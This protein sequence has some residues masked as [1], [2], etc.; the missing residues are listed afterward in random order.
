MA[1]CLKNGGNLSGVPT[2]S[3]NFVATSVELVADNAV[4]VWFNLPPDTGINKA[5]LTIAYLASK[6]LAYNPTLVSSPSSAP[7]AVDL[8]F[9]N[10]FTVGV[11]H[12]FIDSTKLTCGSLQLANN[13]VLAF[14]IANQSEDRPGL[15][16]DT[17]LTRKFF[18]PVFKGKKNWEALIAGLEASREYLD[19][20][21]QSIFKQSYLATATGKYLGARTSN[22]GVV[23]PEEIGL[24]DDTFRELA[25]SIINSKL[26]SVANLELLEIMYGSEST[27]ATMIGSK[28]E[29]FPLFE[30]ATLTINDDQ[31][32]ISVVFKSHFFLDITRGTAAE[33]CLNINSVLQ[34]F[35]SKAFAAPVYDRHTDRTYIRLYSGALG[36]GANI[37]VTAGTAQPALGFS[38]SLFPTL[39]SS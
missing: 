4:R 19:T 36:L 20:L 1:L 10:N 8:Y 14:E 3:S 16:T 34:S 2:I 27:R 31:K 39:P 15:E 21:A 28:F 17:N 35:G 30:G 37:S 24:T 18:N 11:W 22:Y 12:L 26:T 13:T 6:D 29:P 38:G 25:I 9:A 5:N 7:K 32:D 33:V 23:R